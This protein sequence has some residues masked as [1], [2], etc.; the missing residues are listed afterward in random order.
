MTYEE[1]LRRLDEIV[2][3]LEGTGTEL[4]ESVRLY[5]EGK[6]LLDFFDGQLRSAEQKVTVLEGEKAE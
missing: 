5:E 4:A 3:A 6:K 2:R 1:A